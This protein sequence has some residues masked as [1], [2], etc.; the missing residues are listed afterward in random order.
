ME[1]NTSTYIA[2]IQKRG[3]FGNRS[4]IISPKGETKKSFLERIKNSYIYPYDTPYWEIEI[5][6]LGQSIDLYE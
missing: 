4:Y 6:E 3:E 5:Y 2:L 1:S